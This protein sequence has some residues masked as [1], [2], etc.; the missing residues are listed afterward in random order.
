MT[1]GAR[2]LAMRRA[3]TRGGEAQLL[4]R[5]N[6]FIMQRWGEKSA[7]RVGVGGRGQGSVGVRAANPGRSRGR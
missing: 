3:A 1:A 5:A 7:M 6:M 4:A 2:V